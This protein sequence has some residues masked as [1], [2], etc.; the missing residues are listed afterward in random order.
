MPL[1]ARN[2]LFPIGA[3]VDA[4]AA[5]ESVDVGSAIED[6]IAKVADEAVGATAAV[7][8][9]ITVSALNEVMTAA[10]PD[11]QRPAM[12]FEDFSSV[13]ADY[14]TGPLRFVRLM[15]STPKTRSC[16][17]PVTAPVGKFITSG[18]ARP[19]PTTWARKSSPRP[20][21]TKSSPCSRRTR[22]PSGP[23]RSTS[24]PCPPVKMST[25]SRH[26]GH[27]RRRLQ[28]GRRSRRRRTYGR[29]PVRPAPDRSPHRRTEHRPQRPRR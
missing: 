7:Q 18:R 19:G 16:P 23:P 14:R 29:L 21:R 13:G 10:T 9:I 3:G 11:Y 26:A 22:S 27:H 2:E 28:R 17:T 4:G 20:P 1:W 15:F 12:G 5:V 8:A 24:S 6:V 25:R